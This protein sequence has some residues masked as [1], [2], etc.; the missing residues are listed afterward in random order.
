MLTIFGTIDYD[1]FVL[2]RVLSNSWT[3]PNTK[4]CMKLPILARKIIFCLRKIQ[5]FQKQGGCNTPPHPPARYVPGLNEGLINTNLFQTS[6][7]R[8][9]QHISAS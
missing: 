3:Q 6:H 1:Y 9:E 2:I 4:T 5:N 8:R 7:N